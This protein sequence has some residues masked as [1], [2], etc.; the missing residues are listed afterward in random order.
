MLLKMLRVIWSSNDK[1]KK[2]KKDWFCST[3]YLGGSWFNWYFL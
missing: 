2:R 3:W 1:I